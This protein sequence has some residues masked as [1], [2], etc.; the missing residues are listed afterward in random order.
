M[1]SLKSTKHTHTSIDDQELALR[2][3]KSS[4]F[5]SRKLSL[6]TDDINIGEL[7]N[8]IALNPKL[9]KSESH[10]HQRKFTRNYVMSFNGNVDVF[11]WILDAAVGSEVSSDSITQ[12]ICDPIHANQQIHKMRVVKIFQSAA[13]PILVDAY[14]KNNAS[15]GSFILKKGDDLRQDE[16]MM[17]MFQL[18]K[19]SD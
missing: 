13:R 18:S 6:T 14:D 15:I 7:N 4:S 3:R 8:L 10:I 1:I 12:I 11:R 16:N 17:F 19:F 2:R 5:S 9:N